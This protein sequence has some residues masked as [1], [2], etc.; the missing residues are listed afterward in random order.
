MS[1]RRQD[2]RILAGSVGII[3]LSLLLRLGVGMHSYSGTSVN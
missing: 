2:V 1:D 3:C